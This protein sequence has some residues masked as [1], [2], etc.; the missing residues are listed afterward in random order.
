MVEA[1]QSRP[2]DAFYPFCISTPC[3][4]LRDN[5]RMQNSMVY[6]ARAINAGA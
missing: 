5:P 2:L 3:K 6:V 1:W 4:K